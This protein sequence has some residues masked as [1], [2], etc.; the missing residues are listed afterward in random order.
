MAKD[1]CPRC[2]RE[3]Y[4]NPI[5]LVTQAFVDGEYVEMCP[6]CYAEDVQKIHGIKWNP[7]GETASLMFEEAKK[8]YP[9]WG[10]SNG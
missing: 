1:T 10:P 6:L 9:D 2:N 8:Q 5:P 4:D 7:K 3:F